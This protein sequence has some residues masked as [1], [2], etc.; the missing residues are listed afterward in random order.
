LMEAG[1][2]TPSRPLHELEGPA[3]LQFLHQT[4]HRD[5]NSL[6]NILSPFSNMICFILTSPFSAAHS[7][8]FSPRKS[9]LNLFRIVQHIYF[10]LRGS[11]QFYFET[12]DS[13]NHQGHWK[14]RG[15][16]VIKIEIL[17]LYQ[18]VNMQFI[19]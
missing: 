3:W 17:S 13:C 8:S 12:K 11:W 15:R 19:Y 14:R 16:G 9:T 7:T 2:P 10:L 18:A 6:C 1:I 4:I 5:G